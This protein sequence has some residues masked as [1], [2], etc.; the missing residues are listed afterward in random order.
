MDPSYELSI[1][2]RTAHKHYTN[3]E[4]Q[5]E[6]SYELRDLL[7]GALLFAK[8]MRKAEYVTM[9]DP[10]QQHYGARVGG[11]MFLPALCGDLFWCAALLR[12]LGASLS[13]VA[14]IEPTS[15]VCATSLLLLM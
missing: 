2:Q 4:I 6:L 11:L 5:K 10:F 7:T 1:S 12:A 14:G 3:H 15:G 9:L 13:L 8:P